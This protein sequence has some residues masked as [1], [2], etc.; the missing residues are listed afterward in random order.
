MLF[1]QIANNSMIISLVYGNFMAWS[2]DQSISITKTCAVFFKS[3]SLNFWAY[4]VFK[5]S[6]DDPFSTSIIKYLTYP[7]TASP[8]HEW[9]SR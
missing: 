5:P 6:I 2:G 7:M 8:F 1:I 4:C 9:P 3:L